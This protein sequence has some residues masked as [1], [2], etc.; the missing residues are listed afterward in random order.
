MS[1]PNPSPSPRDRHLFGPGAKRILSLDGGGVRG[2]VTIAFLERLETVIDEIEGKPT[3]LCDWFD[4]IGG[5][6]TGAIIAG[7]LALG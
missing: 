6:S 5:T 3:L 7:T 2:A 4:I 1:D